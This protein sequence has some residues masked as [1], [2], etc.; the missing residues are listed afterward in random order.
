M[1]DLN[2]EYDKDSINEVVDEAP[3][4]D[5]YIA[6]RRIRWK[7]EAEFKL[8]IRKYFVKPD[9]S[10]FPGKGVSFMTEDG[11]HMLTECLVANGFGNT[12]KVVDAV[13]AR[14]DFVTELARSTLGNKDVF[15]SDLNNAYSE[16][17]NDEKNKV[18]DAKEMLGQ[19][20]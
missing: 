18:V 20:L 1:A 6:I 4:S 17:V 16:V 12:E 13:S 9:G 15:L 3:G 5:N 2:Y 10:E 7:P 8:D 11:P 14:D 19:L